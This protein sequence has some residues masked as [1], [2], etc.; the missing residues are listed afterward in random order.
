MSGKKPDYI[1]AYPESL[2]LEY[3]KLR[4]ERHMKLANCQTGFS[5][6]R[7]HNRNGKVKLLTP[8]DNYYLLP[9][10]TPADALDHGNMAMVKNSSD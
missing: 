10:P 7:K 1:P 6:V 4:L 2:V 9:R 5:Y 3:A 8:L